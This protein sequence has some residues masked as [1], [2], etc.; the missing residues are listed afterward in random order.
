MQ[1]RLTAYPPD[2]AAITAVVQPG[3]VLR[4]GRAE[5]SGLRV[6][7]PSVSRAHA[8]LR[9]DAGV[10][11]LLDLGS[12]NG[13]FVDGVRVESQSLARDC[14]LRFGDIHCQLAL[15][16]DVE[17]AAALA[18]T[19]ARRAMATAH[20]ARIDRLERIDELLDASLR[21]VVELAQCERGFVLL[22]QRGGFAVCASQ[23]L[24]PGRLRGR[25]FS[26]SV[27]ALGQAL[28]QRRSVIVN[29][30]GS[31]AWLCSRASVVAAG[32]SS[33]VCIPL[34]DGELTLGGI[35][36]DRV[37]PGPPITTLDQELLEAF[38]ERAALWI[39]ARRISEMLDTGQPVSP[40]QSGHDAPAM[41]WDTILAAH[42][43]AA[44]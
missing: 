33:L 3:Q 4:I 40:A 35:Y 34:L 44:R 5:G 31:E 21:G 28:A 14:W 39:S 32:L 29:D 6:M 20:T 12:K 26:G 1:A 7:H 8:E 17:A 42:A 13:S 37:R 27:G 38:A 9:H 22:Q 16:S 19:W 15:L 18:G 43:D 30:I 36:A 25:D 24:D 23:A 2:A 41:D 11:R 10:W